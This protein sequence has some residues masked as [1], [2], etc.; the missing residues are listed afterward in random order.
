MLGVVSVALLLLANFLFVFFDWKTDGFGRP[1][2]F[3]NF[4]I[5]QLSFVFEFLA[6][7]LFVV[8][9]KTP[10]LRYLAFALFCSARM[11][12]TIY[13][14]ANPRYLYLLHSF[15]GRSYEITLER[16]TYEL[17]NFLTIHFLDSIG[18]IA[19]LI[20]TML[21]VAAFVLS[22][23]FNSKEPESFAMPFEKFTAAQ[24]VVVSPS[25]ANTASSKISDIELLGDLLAK[26][27]ITQAEFDRKKREILGFD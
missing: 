14:T 13:N 16:I 4:W 10:I 11:L 8:M 27:L 24:S 12:Y 2:L 9:Y 15:L 26:G 21:F 6:I 22:F 20:S 5:W 7:V 1:Y 19:L 17:S 25:P 18:N 3:Q 23:F